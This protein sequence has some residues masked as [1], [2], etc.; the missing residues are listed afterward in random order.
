[1]LLECAEIP[2]VDLERNVR[3]KMLRKNCHSGWIFL[4]LKR[5]ELPD[6]ETERPEVV[7]GSSRKESGQRKKRTPRDAFGRNKLPE[8]WLNKADL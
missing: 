4:I 1:M 6:H 5:S 8:K 3:V 7:T 2:S